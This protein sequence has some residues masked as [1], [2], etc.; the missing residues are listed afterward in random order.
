M[1]KLLISL[2]FLSILLSCSADPDV[3]S[4]RQ[5]ARRILP[6]QAGN[7]EFVREVADTDFYAFEAKGGRLTVKANNANS[8]AV[9]LNN[10]LKDF[11]HV[12]VSWY[13]E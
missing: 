9:G 6:A 8:M 3:Q 11:C 5:L 7:I 10:Y 13:A 12:T 4:A 1:K 2:T